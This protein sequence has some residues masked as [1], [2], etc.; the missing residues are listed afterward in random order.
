[1]S[2]IKAYEKNTKK[3]KQI[4]DGLQEYYPQYKDDENNNIYADNSLFIFRIGE[5]SSICMAIT[6][7]WKNIKIT[8]WNIRKN[9]DKQFIVSNTNI[10]NI[11]IMIELF[12]GR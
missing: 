10:E 8:M 4:W 12:M 2:S 7:D 6:N 9:K 5:V 3:L 1:M 11:I